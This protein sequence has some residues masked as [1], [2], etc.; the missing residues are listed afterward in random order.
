MAAYKIF[1][2][3]HRRSLEGLLAPGHFMMFVLIM[4]ATSLNDIIG[5]PVI[6]ADDIMNAVSG[7]SRRLLYVEPLSS[8]AKFISPLQNPKVAPD[9]VDAPSEA[10]AT[11]TVFTR[12]SKYISHESVINFI[13]REKSPEDAL[14]IFNKASA[15]SGFQHN[16]S[17]YGII[18]HKLAQCKKYQAL[19][20]VLHRMTYE[21]CRFH[22]GIFLN[23]MNHFSKASKHE[24]VLEM[25]HS[26]LPIVRSQ[27][28]LKAISACLNLLVDANETDLARKFLL[29]TQKDFHL[30]PN[31]C[32]FNIV[33][34]HHCKKGDIESAF[35]VMKEMEKSEVSAP[36]LITYSTVIDGLCASG[37]LE[38]AIQLFEEMVSKHQIVP[39]ALTYNAL[40]NGFCRGQ[41]TDRAKKIMEFMKKNGC[42]P[43]IFNYSSLM[44][45]YCKDGKLEE[46]KGVL[47]EMKAAGLSPD[48]VVYTTLINWLCRSSKTNEAIEL[49]K[50]MKENECKADEVTFNV[51]LGGLCRE[52]RYIEALNMLE[53]LPNDGVY[54]NKASYR[55]VLNSLCKERELEKA[56]DLLALMLHRDFVPHVGTSNELLVSLC[57]AGKVNDAV[58]LLF[59]L[60]Q[61]G[62]KPDPLTWS[63]LIDLICRERKLLL[64]FELLDELLK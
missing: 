14:E 38:D 27:P 30:K 61:R 17:T 25:F 63:V 46:A 45:G 23:L 10:T 1:K 55:I 57:N 36:N 49:L 64:A 22:E 11:Q 24:R 50:E 16:N 40:I 44:N 34:K 3:S 12:K 6:Y 9:G 13:K 20:G 8:S 15:Q 56:V 53:R 39:D 32:I 52:H 31:T 33:I 21:T 60:V 7:K 19:D 58:R 41:K 47:N 35:V 37:R 4:F 48:T 28:S 62:L 51:I 18:L 42:N 29:S 43:N 54:L 59:G 2:V 26:I 5:D